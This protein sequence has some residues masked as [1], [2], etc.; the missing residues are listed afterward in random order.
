MYCPK[1]GRFV[2]VKA[3]VNLLGDVVRLEAKCKTHGNVDVSEQDYT[4]EELVGD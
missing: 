1:C 2:K 4:Y 3:F